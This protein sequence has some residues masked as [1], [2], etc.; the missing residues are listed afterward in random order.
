MFAP[1]SS[2]KPWFFPKSPFHSELGVASLSTVIHFQ[3]FSLKAK[4][5]ELFDCGFRALDAFGDAQLR[6]VFGKLPFL[7]DFDRMPFENP[8]FAVH[9]DTAIPLVTSAAF[10]PAWIAE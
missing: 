3:L 1:E 9:E 7:F 6:A 8:V 2:P 10:N 5:V 4:C